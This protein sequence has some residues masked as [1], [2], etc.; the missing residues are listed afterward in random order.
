MNFAFRD[1]I[2]GTLFAGVFVYLLMAGNYQTWGDPSVVILALPATF[3]GIVTILYITGT[4][5]SVSSLRRATGHWCRL[6]E[7]HPAR[8]LCARAA[9]RR[10]GDI[11]R[12]HPHP[13]ALM[14]A[15]AVIV[16]T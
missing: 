16:G 7:F 6:G 4:T 11:R 10:C 14:T 2:I 8:D 1:L 5:L 12:P 13:P 3:C 15:A 9:T